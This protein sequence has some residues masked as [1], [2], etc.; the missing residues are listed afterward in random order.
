MTKQ[1][2]IAM[3]NKT[4]K[5]C[6]K[7]IKRDPN[8]CMICYGKATSISHKFC[9]NNCKF[10][11]CLECLFKY[12]KVYGDG[13]SIHHIHSTCLICRKRYSIGPILERL[14]R[15][16]A[17]FVSKVPHYN[18][19]SRV[20]IVFK[21][22]EE[23]CVGISEIIEKV[24]KGTVQNYVTNIQDDDTQGDDEQDTINNLENLQQQA[25]SVLTNQFP[26]TQQHQPINPS[27]SALQVLLPNFNPMYLQYSPRTFQRE[28]NNN[29]N[30]LNL[31]HD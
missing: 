8:Q 25:I 29:N 27:L 11:Y 5:K 20:Y 26:T 21:L 18:D 24:K 10:S 28:L 31:N 4:D 1:F 16:R 17:Y 23:G 6:C 15:R 22:K 7:R 30:Q 9:E 19:K 12:C 3:E 2:S 13:T 14:L